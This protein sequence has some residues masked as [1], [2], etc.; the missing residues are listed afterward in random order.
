MSVAS[1]GQQQVEPG[2]HSVLTQGLV[3]QAPLGQ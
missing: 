2:V 1:Y 3:Q